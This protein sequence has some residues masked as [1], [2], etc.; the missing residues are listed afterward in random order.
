MV[1][2][3]YTQYRLAL[4][5]LLVPS[6][7]AICIELVEILR[8][9]RRLFMEVVYFWKRY[10]TQMDDDYVA[11]VLFVHTSSYVLASSQAS[12][13]STSPSYDRDG[14]QID[15]YPS[16][17]TDTQTHTQTDRHTD[18]Q[19]HRQTHRQIH[20]Q[21]AQIDRYRY[22]VGQAERYDREIDTH[23][24]DLGVSVQQALTIKALQY[25]CCNSPR[26]LMYW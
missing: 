7:H 6:S 4:P 18:R 17:H 26:F 21:I 5:I 10:H 8:K 3:Q 14:S 16:R 2:V 25:H 19:T 23:N 1:H 9:E 24:T 13:A 12:T 15:R 22:L 20:K 11:S